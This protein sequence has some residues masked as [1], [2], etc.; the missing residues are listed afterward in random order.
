[1]QQ[2]IIN[3]EKI[4]Q[5]TIDETMKLNKTQHGGH[6]RRKVFTIS[7]TTMAAPTK[8]NRTKVMYITENMRLF[9]WGSVA[10]P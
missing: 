1:M 6:Q 3:T 8:N 9:Q 7:V 4:M 2:A 10:A 5:N